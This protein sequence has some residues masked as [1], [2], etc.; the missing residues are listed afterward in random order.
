[1]P[2]IVKNLETGE[3]HVDFEI[4][5]QELHAIGRVTTQW[6]YLEHGVFAVTKSIA[7]LIG[8]ALPKDAL[9]TAFKRRLSAL[10]IL[11]EEFAKDG[12]RKRMLSLIGKIANAEQDRHKITHA[13]WEW[14]VDKPDQI[15]ATSFRP[16]YEFEKAFDADKMNA[17]ANRIGA[18]SFLLQYPNGMEDVWS[19]YV[20]ENGKVAYF[21]KSRKLYQAIKSDKSPS[22]QPFDL[23]KLIKD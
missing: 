10:R 7:E 19:D 5:A 20:D 4:D 2:Q 9:S 8:T 11:V 23:S 15:N 3:I 13:M 17:L 6:A 21:N 16:G 1:M 22:P 18:I 14:D 12:E